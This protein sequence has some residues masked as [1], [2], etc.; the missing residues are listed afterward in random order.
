[1]SSLPNELTELIKIKNLILS[2]YDEI[3]PLMIEYL[4]KHKNNEEE[5]KKGTFYYFCEKANQT[6]N[7]I[8][9][10]IEKGCINDAYILLR[11]LFEV[12][13]TC[14]YIYFDIPNRLPKFLNFGWIE[15]KRRID[16]G[17]IRVDKE[18]LEEINKNFEKYKNDYK[19]KIYWE[20]TKVM[21]EDEEVNQK[22]DY[23]L[24]FLYCSSLL[25]VNPLAQQDY[26][27]QKADY[28]ETSRVFWSSL[29]YSLCILDNINEIFKLG[30]GDRIN[31][32]GHMIE[33]Y[34]K[35]YV[36]KIE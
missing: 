14:R 15:S 23:D 3:M 16:K 24:V 9:L 2:I 31:G 17:V 35:K 1:M 21:A 13:V 5:Q 11:S 28:Q 7:A 6:L 32:T 34:G 20:S 8:L 19:S 36:L 22:N 10:L 18:Q 30:L 27:I 33:D 4:E 29:W 12:Q 25:H 26:F